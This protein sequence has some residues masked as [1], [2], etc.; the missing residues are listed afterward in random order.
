[1]PKSNFA[2]KH[3]AIIGGGLAGLAAATSLASKGIQCTLFEASGQLGGR[4]RTVT[5]VANNHEGYKQSLALDNGQHIL[6]GAYSQTLKLLAMVGVLESEAFL[7]VPLSLDMRKAQKSVFKLSTWYLLPAP[8]NQL[9]GFIFC[10]GLSLNERIA[11]IKFMLLLKKTQYQLTNDLPLKDF[12]QQHQQPYHLITWLWEPLCLA[13]LNT[14]LNIAS[15]RV[16]LNVLRD[17]FASKNSADFLLP[18]RDLSQILSQ[19]IARYLTEQN[20]AIW[21]NQRVSGIKPT[22]TGFNVHVK[23][24]A[25]DTMISVSDVIIAAPPA[26]LSDFA[27]DLP[28]LNAAT[29]QVNGYSYQPIFTIYLQYPAH[30]TIGKSMVGLIGSLSQWVFD[31]GILC[32]QPGL[33][34]V[35]I[36]ANGQHQQYAQD[37]LGLMVAQE[38]QAAFPQLEK[39]LWHKVI[40]EKRATF[41]CDVNLP[42]PAHVT[43][44]PNLYLAGDYTFADYPA[45]IE[46]AV[47]S[48]LTCADLVI[49]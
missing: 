38:L 10:S 6:L 5:I 42:R 40:A 2:A 30:A 37:E 7:R 47:R 17:T 39:P 45:T 20:T 44:Y 32:N 24:A 21:L 36:S 27:I 9:F 43:P 22:E 29:A 16:F 35:I 34:A 1:M 14:P 41:S 13:A 3:V 15:S 18:K 33:M 49:Q 4:A 48:G 46:G 19:P 28:L 31:R 26:R 8:L 25:M 11:V 12:L 23:Q